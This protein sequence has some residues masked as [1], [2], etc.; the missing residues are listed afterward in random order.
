MILDRLNDIEINVA[1]E[2][3]DVISEEFDKEVL[4]MTA[5]KL[6]YINIK[7][8]HKIKKINILKNLKKNNLSIENKEYI[9]T[10]EEKSIKTF[11]SRYKFGR[12]K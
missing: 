3:L 7:I 1:E 5:N 6:I 12:N 2:E 10:N 4:K 11:K 9:I 8:I